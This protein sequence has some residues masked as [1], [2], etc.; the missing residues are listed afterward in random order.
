MKVFTKVREMQAFSESLRKE[1]KIIA[2]VPTMGYFHEGHLNLMREGRKRGDCLVVSIYVNPT[3]FGPNEDLN[4]YPRDFERDSRLAR[5]VGVDVIFYPPDEE[6]YPPNYQTYVN[7]EKVT[8]NLCGISRP[9]H[10]RGVTTVCCKL[11]NIVKPHVTIFGKKDFQQLVTIKRMVAD[12]NI[13]LEVVAMPTTREPD[14]LAMSSRN[15]YL[16]PG[17]RVSALSLSK[18]LKLAKDMYEQGERDAGSIISE[19]R[20]FIESHPYTK[21]DYV[22]ICDTATLEDVQKIEG[23]C[24]IA[25]AVFVGSARL[26]DNYVFGEEL[27]I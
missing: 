25:L 7:V 17:E 20:R 27:H 5:D 6:M 16:S 11:F 2:F 15:V 22:K 1:G 14:G 21:I 26:I 10:F 8:Q 18:S 13:D 24:V 19:V 3:Q 23:E 12:L 9:G 4:R